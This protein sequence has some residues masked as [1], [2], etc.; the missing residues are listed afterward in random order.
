MVA[1]SESLI[2]KSKSCKLRKKKEVEYLQSFLE[3]C[4]SPTRL[5]EYG[6]GV[7][8]EKKKPEVGEQAK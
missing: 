3:K 5:S 8:E 1:V 4:G 2:K 7:E 6:I